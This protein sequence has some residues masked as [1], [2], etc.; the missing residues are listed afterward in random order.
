MQH[1]EE[2]ESKSVEEIEDWFLAKLSED[3]LPVNEMLSVLAAEGSADNAS[4]CDEWAE[5]LQD[6]L[7]EKGDGLAVLQLLDL[8]HQWQQ[9]ETSFRKLCSGA[10]AG[11]FKDRLGQALVK[12]VGF[13][14][15]QNTTECLRRLNV[16]TGLQPGTLCRDK[17]WGFGV[18]TRLDDFYQKV[19]IDFSRKPGH[20]MS[21]SYAGETLEILDS[22]HLMAR[23]HNDP[24]GLAELTKE[25]PGEVVR[26]ALRSYGPKSAPDMQELLVR[27]VVPEADWKAFWDGARKE[28]KSDPLVDMPSRRNEPIRLLKKEKTYDREW[29]GRFSANKDPAEI[30]VLATEIAG[31]AGAVGVAEEFRPKVGERLGFALLGCHRKQPGL[32]VRL[33]SLTHRMGLSDCAGKGFHQAIE[34]LGSPEHFIA[35]G[36]AASAKDMVEVIHFL[37]EEDPD[38]ASEL[39]LSVLNRLPFHV[40]NETLEL[41]LSRGKQEEV[42]SLLRSSIVSAEA[43]PSLLYWLC[44]NPARM[45][46]WSISTNRELLCQV[47]DSLARPGGGNRLKAC[48]Q[49]R[50][51]VEQK[52]WFDDAVAGLVPLDREFILRRIRGLRGLDETVKRSLMARMIK[53]YP[54]LQRV[55]ASV[56]EE[57]VPARAKA[58]LTSWRSYRERRE[59]H[60]KLVETTIPQNSRDIATARSYGD[61]R[62]NFEYQTAKEQQ[63]LLMRRKDEIERDLSEVKGTDFSGVPTDTAGLGT[64][65]DLK[66]ADG[67]TSS[68]CILGEWDRDEALGVISCGS[69][70]AETLDG[71]REGDE[72][73]LPTDSGDEPCRIAAITGLTDVIRQWIGRSEDREE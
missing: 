28:L 61:L 20:Q 29:F 65:I 9:S 15:D 16:L 67:R 3:P 58:R 63:A 56:D 13:D 12:S 64:C 71:H 46:E 45:E 68:Y 4:R 23:K 32:A 25:S 44:K 36:W 38:S 66:R 18:V 55:L 33:I 31:H 11:A 22:D 57:T 53:L 49:L 34:L 1:P 30:L 21:F 69:R 2:T 60:R 43:S 48:K 5:L 73:L 14:T 35:S 52:G 6:A 47:M 17:T 24:E 59:Q 26:I 40:M 42:I 19:N 51:S 50:G 72:I 8:R 70:L 10:A 27:D 62:E 41:L 7:V 54:E 37:G 39:L